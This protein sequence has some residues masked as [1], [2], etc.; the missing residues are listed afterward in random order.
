MTD[1]PTILGVYSFKKEEHVG[2]GTTSTK[3][4]IVTHWYAR[5]LNKLDIEVQ[6]LNGYH[7][8][9]GIRKIITVDDFLKTY[10]PEPK[11]YETHT[12]PAMKTL[13]EK[14]DQ[15]EK[16]FSMGLL[17]QSE[18]SFIKALMI[19]DINIEANYGL[20]EVY[21][22]TKEYLKLRQVLNTLLG[23]DEAFNQV[24]MQRINSFGVSL[25]KNGHLAEAINFFNKALEINNNDENLYFNIA[26]VHFDKGDIGACLE[27]LRSAVGLN[28]GFV[29][30]QKFIGYCERKLVE[31]RRTA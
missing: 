1:Y 9:S 15:G 2:A 21:S 16:A 26:R 11:Y 7:I 28:D 13:K 17:D 19:D 8:P 25:R 29:E 18:K 31:S 3:Q 22:K 12:V 23:L 27:C 10:V 5:Q 14:I 20:G 6:P 30:A 24:H 4:S